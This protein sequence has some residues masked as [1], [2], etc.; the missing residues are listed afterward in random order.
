[1]PISE[2]RGGGLRIGGLV[3]GLVLSIGVSPHA[4][5]EEVPAPAGRAPAIV[6]APLN[7]P[8]PASATPVMPLAG[9]PSAAPG[10]VPGGNPPSAHLPSTSLP[11]TLANP[12]ATPATPVPGNGALTV[13]PL[14]P[15]AVPFTSFKS[16]TEAFALG[17]RAYLSGD[18]A[19]AV[20][21]LE[22][23]ATKGHPRANWKLGRMYAEGDGV[24][25]DDLKAFEY[26]SRIADDHADVPPGSPNARF[27]ANAF[28]T[29]GSYFLVGISGTYVRANPPR[30][31]EIFNYAATYFGDP[32]A[33]FHLGRMLLDGVASERDPRQAARW[34]YL[35]AEKGFAPA[36]ATLGQMLVEG[37]GVPRQVA[38]GL[39][40]LQ[41]ARDAADPVKDAWILESHDKAFTASSDN[42]RQA[43]LFYLEQQARRRQ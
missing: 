28:V 8:V 33:Q 37:N 24:D 19:S 32:A 43:A 36:Q 40:W 38:R 25:H 29:L 26:F 30:A 14:G 18:K 21:A 3:C 4:M 10:A 23:A 39:M 27:V 22:Y 17:M 31:R 15:A 20:R 35:A 34:L 1:M 7:A 16:E 9:N 12:L 6:V 41:V 13:A 2:I 5:A 42:D 11:A